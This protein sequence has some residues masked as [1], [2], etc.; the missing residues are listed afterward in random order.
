MFIKCNVCKI[1]LVAII[2]IFQF[3]TIYAYD[4]RVFNAD[5]KAIFYNKGNDGR[6]AI[7]T[8][9]SSPGTYNGMINIPATVNYEG[10]NYT[11]ISIGE[12]AFWTCSNLSSVSIPN[13]VKRIENDAFKDCSS[14]VSISI[15]SS[16][17]YI[18]NS[19][20]LTVNGYIPWFNQLYNNAP[21][22]MFYINSV[23]YK[24]KGSMPNNT[25][26]TLKEGTSSISGQAFY[27]CTGLTGINIP[28][29]VAEIGGAAFYNC[30]N[31]AGITLPT[32][33]T[34]IEN[35][36]FYNCNALKTIVLPENVI[37]IGLSAFYNCY[38]LTSIIMGH[39]VTTILDNA[40]ESCSRLTSITIPESV[41]TM[42]GSVFYG[43]SSLTS[44]VIPDNV[45]SI[46]TN[47]F[48]KCTSLKS[49]TIGKSVTSIGGEAFFNCTS[50]K[51]IIIPASVTN[52]A[53]G[54]FAYCYYLTG[55]YIESET[56]P[57]LDGNPFN[58]SSSFS[59]SKDTL[60]VPSANAKARYEA[61]NWND[62]FSVITEKKNTTGINSVSYKTTVSI[63]K[64]IL[65]VDSPLSETISV[66]S[67]NGSLLF[68][69]EKKIGKVSFNIP[70][71]QGIIIV[72][73]SSGW[74]RKIITG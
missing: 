11:V 38:G 17:I 62:F 56:P 7:V 28:Q 46:G 50:L 68:E 45:T 58:A 21:D 72:T 25:V 16:V 70:I 15:P 69:V 39:K 55:V 32:G 19:A 4:F 1:W 12:S 37:S 2:L 51:S 53:E 27:N 64:G 36:T 6:S 24:Y 31:L 40:F 47:T 59:V 13:T 63:I 22:G 49:V 23:L 71:I 34:S 57:V 29:S 35:A 42:R 26:I 48:V 74:T 44:I 8:Y 20:F 18:S 54:A 30:Q 60:Y 67:V 41:T 61:S 65:D 43:C 3:T 66:Y 33:I 73:G 5:E 52:I 14:L 10:I 9:G